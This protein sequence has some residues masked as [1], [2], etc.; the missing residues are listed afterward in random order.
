M[1]SPEDKNNSD[2]SPEKN[3]AKL[4]DKNDQER[5]DELNKRFE[6]VS[7]PDI[8]NPLSM[9]SLQ[10]AEKVSRKFLKEDTA[11]Y[12]NMMGKPS[13]LPQKDWDEFTEALRKSQQE[14]EEKYRR[15]IRGR[16]A[17]F[18]SKFKKK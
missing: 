16:I 8:N 6:G 13:A 14:R 11:G 10:E 18:L 15:S 1:N 7:V 3:P 4:F 9:G 5:I 17:S 2:N 12:F